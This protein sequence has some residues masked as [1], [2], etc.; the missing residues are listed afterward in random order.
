[1]FRAAKDAPEELQKAAWSEYGKFKAK[2]SSLVSR[3]VTN[4]KR[5]FAHLVKANDFDK[6]TQYFWSGQRGH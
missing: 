2:A 4:M 1:M 5:E 6:G 3:V